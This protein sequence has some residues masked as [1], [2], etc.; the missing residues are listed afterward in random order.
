MPWLTFRLRAKAR[1]IAAALGEPV[2]AG[3][4]GRVDDLPLISGG[5]SR[6]SEAGGRQAQYLRFNCLIKSNLA[7]SATAMTAI[8]PAWTGSLT[9]RSAA[10][11]TLPAIFREIT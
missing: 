5:G 10:S 1:Q 11:G 8:T 2:S 9:T 3:D 7:V 4:D 6:W